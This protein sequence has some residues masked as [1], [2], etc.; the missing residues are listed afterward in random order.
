M[1]VIRCWLCETVCLLYNAQT[2]TLIGL[3][4]Q[5][6][7]LDAE[8]RNLAE[9]AE[10]RLVQD[11]GSGYP[12]QPSSSVS[13]ISQQT[14]ADSHI[15]TESVPSLSHSPRSLAST[16]TNSRFPDQQPQPVAT[17]VNPQS[18]LIDPELRAPGTVAAALPPIRPTSYDSPYAPR[19]QY[20]QPSASASG[21]TAVAP[22]K[23]VQQHTRPSFEAG[24][25]SSFTSEE[26]LPHIQQLTTSLIPQQAS[27]SHHAIQPEPANRVILSRSRETKILLS[28][29][30]DG[31]RGLSSLLI[32]ESLVNAICAKVDQR[33]DAHQ[34]FDLTG[35]SSLGGVLAILLCR[36]QMQPRRARE[37]YKRISKQVFANKRN[38][39]TSFDP[40]TAHPETNSKALEDEIKSVVAEE[41]GNPNELLPDS[42][43]DAGDV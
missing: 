42:R 21:A 43:P 31:V 33:L 27:V 5:R 20:S 39:Y 22:S 17:V 23:A 25:G 9:E 8:I 18:P 7:A 34:I 30:G 14:H 1:G 4:K 3:T 37:A 36:L 40:P 6:R 2:S 16:S 11:P 41:L 19:A 24:H 35:G 12:R 15:H 26:R 10:K 13:P 38:Y 29:D 32:V 28:I